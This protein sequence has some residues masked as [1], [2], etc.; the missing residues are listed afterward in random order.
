MYSYLFMNLPIKIIYVH[1]I[2]MKVLMLFMLHTW[3]RCIKWIKVDAEDGE[4][5]D[6]EQEDGEQEVN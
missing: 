5:E 1:T 6:G 3:P 2:I 4:Q